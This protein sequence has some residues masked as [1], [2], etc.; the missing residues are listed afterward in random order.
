MDNVAGKGGSETVKSDLPSSTTS[1][2]FTHMN[3]SEAS[4]IAV[5]VEDS[6]PVVWNNSKSNVPH[7]PVP[8][9]KLTKNIVQYLYGSTIFWSTLTIN[10]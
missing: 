6:K 5:I 8:W 4:D 3:E 7:T 2:T 1:I 9:G 10:L